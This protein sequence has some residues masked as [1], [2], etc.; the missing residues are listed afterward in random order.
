M[1]E[2]YAMVIVVLVRVDAGGDVGHRLCR[3]GSARIVTTRLHG[4]ERRL[5]SWDLAAFSRSPQHGRE[6]KSP[7]DPEEDRDCLNCTRLAG[8]RFQ[9]QPPSKGQNWRFAAVR[10]L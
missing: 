5:I 4:R 6:K 9:F 10:T 3:E 7:L 2:R 8:R 1:K